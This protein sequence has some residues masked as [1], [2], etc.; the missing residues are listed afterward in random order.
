MN[1]GPRGLAGKA[2]VRRLEWDCAEELALFEPP[3]DVVI[4]GDCLYEEACISPLLKTMWALSG[5]H[6]EVPAVRLFRCSVVRFP[7]GCWH[8]FCS[9]FRVKIDDVIALGV[10]DRVRRSRPQFWFSAALLPW[11]I[12]GNLTWCQA[13]PI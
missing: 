2:L 4:A 11:C 1:L 9:Y 6:T 10:G 13:G 8:S 7:H 12:A 3:Y 5:P